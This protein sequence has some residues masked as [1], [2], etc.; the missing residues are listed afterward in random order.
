[1]E[2]NSIDW[3]IVYSNDPHLSEYTAECDRLRERISG[4][5]GSAGTLLVS[6]S[7][8]YLWT[9]SR[10][11]IQAA[12]QL[13]GSG[14]SLMKLQEPGVP[15]LSEYLGGHIWDGQVL[16]VDKKTISYD[17]YKSLCRVL[18]TSTE[19]VDGGK[20]LRQ[21]CNIK[22]SF[23]D[24]NEVP[25]EYR[26]KE[27]KEK[28][29]DVRKRISGK[30]PNGVSYTY[31][32][33]DLTSVMWMYDLRGNDIRHVPVAYSYTVINAYS[34]VLYISRKN[35]SD[36]AAAMLEEAGVT[37]KEYSQFYGG[38]SDI[39]TD[40]VL[41][42]TYRNN[43]LILEDIDAAGILQD[44]SDCEIIR[45]PVKSASEI[46]G[47]TEAHIKDAVTMIRFI[48]NVKQTARSGG[49]TNEYDIGNKLD[50]SRLANGCCDMS[51]DTICAY[52]PNAAIVHY[53]A[54]SDTCAPVR[55]SGFLLVDSGGQY[56]Y[57]GTTDITRTISLGELTQEEI[58]AY[59]T[60]LRANL[61]LMDMI[62]P[63]GCKGTLLDAAAEEVLWE[64]GYYCGHGIGHGVGCY[65]SVHESEIRIS[66]VA[67]KRE[68]SFYPGVIVS[69]EPGVYVEGK[70]GVR[71]ENLLL[72]TSAGQIDGHRMCRFTP[73]TLV[74]FDMEAVDRSMLTNKEREILA[75]YNRLI[76]EK[77]SP[78]LEKDEK[79]WLKE[80]IDID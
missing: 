8:A 46:K 53:T 80:N 77:V 55:S 20:L 5:T 16:A 37:V 38:L 65:L 41:A 39:A 79:D 35:L 30:I 23:N 29:D 11:Y 52:G 42:D 76:W 58:R 73:L 64:N 7:E 1:M 67:G 19:V 18:P 51:F 49:L 32:L 69:D 70:L 14:I 74:P 17:E 4:F 75:E 22:R 71:L 2:Q 15:S 57:M 60:V 24:V 50:E 31:I 33:S 26:G 61:R 68:C 47:M 66:R 13:K 3:F 62:F 43:A 45:K 10:Y 56:E 9:D 54:Q 36:G 48:K 40:I 6:A 28:I 25:R 72:V 44:V 27:I 63:E 34:A 59:T 12:D 21:L 78:F